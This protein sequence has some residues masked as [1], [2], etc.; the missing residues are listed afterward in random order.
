VLTVAH[1]VDYRQVLG[2]DEKLLV[3]TIQGNKLPAQVVLVCDEP[4]GVDLALLEISSPGFGDDLL[5]VTFV[6]VNRE[7]PAPVP[8]CWAVGFPL[9]G[10]ADP[11]LQGGSCRETWEVRGDILPGGKRRAGLLALQV[12]ST[13]QPLPTSEA[14]SRWE[15]MSGAVVFTTDPHGGEQ[16]VGI[17]TTHHRP[18]GES[19]LTVAPVAAIAQLP[20]A[21]QW[22]HQLADALKLKLPALEDMPVIGTP[23]ARR[24]GRGSRWLFEPAQARSHFERRAKG[25]RSG[26]AD[27]DLFRGRGAAL[28]RIRSWFSA[29]QEPELPLVVTGQ[30][31]AGKSAVIARVALQFSRESNS[32]GLAFHAANATVAAFRAALANLA[33]LAGDAEE[34]AILEELRTMGA[35]GVVPVVVDALDEAQTADDRRQIAGMIKEELAGLPGLRLAVATRP[36]TTGNRFARGSLLCALGVTADDSASLVD[37]DTDMY[38]EP[39]G[40]EEYA[41]LVLAQS[42]RRSPG[43]GRAWIEYERDNELCSRVASA[44]AARAGR[45]Y[46]VAGLAASALSGDEVVI[47]P[48]AEYDPAQIPGAV[49]EALDKYLGRM[50]PDREV[51]VRGLL[52][53]LAYAREGLDDALWLRFTAALFYP[54]TPADLDELRSTSIADFLVQARPGAVPVTTLFHQALR[55]ELLRART[56]RV[57]SD[58]RAITE[59]LLADA[60]A[61]PGGSANW[62]RAHPYTLRHLASHAGTADDGGSLHDRLL[63]DAGYLCA[64]EPGPLL[65]ALA[66]YAGPL[67]QHVQTYERFSEHRLASAPREWPAY[68]GLAAAQT[69]AAELGSAAANLSVAAAWRPRWAAWNP[70]IPHRVLDRQSAEVQAI[71]SLR[72]AGRAALCIGSSVSLRVL[73]AEDGQCLAQ[74]DWPVEGLAVGDFP[75]GC[76]VFARNARGDLLLWE[77][78]EQGRDP[79]ML[80]SP[81]GPRPCAVAVGQTGGAAMAVA[82]TGDDHRPITVAGW[83]L[84]GGLRWK[85]Q[86][87]SGV[88]QVTVSRLGS[89]DVAFVSSSPRGSRCLLFAVGLEDGQVIDQWNLDDSDVYYPTPLPGNGAAR[90]AY[91][92]FRQLVIVEVAPHTVPVYWRVPGRGRREPVVTG[93]QDNPLLACVDESGIRFW[94]PAEGQDFGYSWLGRG[95]TSLAAVSRRDRNYI[96]TGHGDGTVRRWHL[97]TLLSHRSDGPPAETQDSLST[98]VTAAADSVLVGAGHRIQRR[99]L[100]HGRLLAETS[101]KFAGRRL[102]LLAFGNQ[103]ERLANYGAGGIISLSPDSLRI[104]HHYDADELHWIEDM[105]TVEVAGQMLLATVGRDSDAV[106]IWSGQTMEHMFRLDHDK[107]LLAVRF[108]IEGG[109]PVILAG[110]TDREVSLWGLTDI[111]TAPTRLVDDELMVS[112]RVVAW[113]DEYVRAIAVDAQ[114]PNRFVSVGLDG[115]VRITDVDTNQ[116]VILYPP[117]HGSLE[118]CCCI[119]RIVLAGGSAG[120]LTAWRLDSSASLETE[121]GT[122]R[123]RGR[124]MAH[125][126]E[127]PLFE[128][129][130]DAGI[131]DITACPGGI[132]VAT[133]D[134]TIALNAALNGVPVTTEP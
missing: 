87:G 55:E 45:N 78:E 56:D 95:I 50:P 85:R 32:P 133:D 79:I 67:K 12:T 48:G 77:P 80:G 66:D 25:Q 109:D 105:D 121:S 114:R 110:G 14:G 126:S 127:Q 49:G 21:A 119:G 17:I 9:F 13:P 44:V 57:I 19:A 36:L 81:I 43:G 116:T 33:G 59:M 106:H 51:R 122:R 1:N 26:A 70:T 41:A 40:L 28:L 96:V 8:N 92:D 111:L 30:P 29:P 86:L 91:S 118:A 84:N 60:L 130:L 73:D 38:F 76:V 42:T 128:I 64:A 46:L 37:L 34:I 103:T 7:S 101:E 134:G 3:R 74:T 62:S 52:T 120:I 113:H 18:E 39:A 104:L 98:A 10:E 83:N 35:H 53:A 82:V 27:S 61:M 5:P 90:L 68:L 6:Q 115:K 89:T 16:A 100:P 129:R 71:R 22:W 124:S 93:T 108:A 94:S 132:I 58:E 97:D 88:P 107:T 99:D 69:G 131:R 65:E 31:G 112:Q 47:D 63:E 72:F 2:E 20:T 117:H 125:S 11:V 23:A 15:G 4:C 24:L 102:R 123:Q 75:S 54:A